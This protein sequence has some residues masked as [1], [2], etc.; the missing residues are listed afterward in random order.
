MY[1]RVVKIKGSA[2]ILP[3]R[4]FNLTAVVLCL[5]GC[6]AIPTFWGQKVA[7][8]PGTR[9]NQSAR[10]LLKNCFV[11]QYLSVAQALSLEL[12]FCLTALRDLR[13]SAL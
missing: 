2:D 13:G 3:E 1:L 12:A 11:K 4:S 7:K 5:F 6:R 10:A 9:K 8:S